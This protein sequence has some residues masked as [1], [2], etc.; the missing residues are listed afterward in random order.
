MF[1]ITISF[2]EGKVIGWVMMSVL[3][4][5]G[6]FYIAVGFACYDPNAQP[7]PKGAINQSKGLDDH[8]VDPDLRPIG[9]D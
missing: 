8:L 1:L 9:H 5:V 3:F 6:C 2:D 4:V 7:V